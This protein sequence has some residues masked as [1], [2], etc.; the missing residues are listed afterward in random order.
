M[1]WE[2]KKYSSEE[3]ST[4]M[5]DE[6]TH[7]VISS[8]ELCEISI[9]VISLKFNDRLYDQQKKNRHNNFDVCHLICK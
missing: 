9:D 6:W 3:N 5:L 1:S 8:S 7:M 2:E 4:L